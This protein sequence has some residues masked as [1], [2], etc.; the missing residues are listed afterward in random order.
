[1]WGVV[2]VVVLSEGLIGGWSVF[3]LTYMIFDN[4]QFLQDY[5]PEGLHSFFAGCCP[6]ATLNSLPHGL[7]SSAAHRRWFAS[8]N[9]TCPEEVK[10]EWRWK[11][12][13]KCFVVFFHLWKQL[14]RSNPHTHGEGITQ[15]HGYQEAGSIWEPFQKLLTIWMHTIWFLSNYKCYDSSLLDD[16]NRILTGLCIFSPISLW[17]VFYNLVRIV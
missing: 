16:F 11:G 15:G 14:T 2:R 17:P 8:S 1:M 10:R 5:W 4:I 13:D 6:E 3:K 12:S 7:L 9:C